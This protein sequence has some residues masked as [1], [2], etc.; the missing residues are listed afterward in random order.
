MSST[1][2]HDRLAGLRLGRLATPWLVYALFFV[3]GV[4][5]AAVV[6]LL[7]RLSARYG[8][9]GAETALLLA[10]PGLATLAVSVPSGLAADRFGARRVTLAAGVLLCLAC[11]SE[12]APSLIALLLGRVAFGIA[13]GVVWTTGMAWLADVDEM[14]A[15]RLGPSVTW[16]S[17]G[18]MVGPAVGGVL[19]QDAGLAAPFMAI[20]LTTAVVIVPLAFA[21]GHARRHRPAAGGER[22]RAGSPR[23]LLSLVR[24]PRVRAAAG[25][26]VVSGAVSSASQLLISGDLHRLDMSTGRIGLLFSAA[27]VCYLVV[28]AAIV[29][30]GDR[31]RTLRFN[32]AATAVLALGLLP[33]LAGAGVLALVAALLLTAAPRAAISTIAYSLAADR[34]SE[35]TD[36]DGFVFGI[37]NGAWAAATVL[38]PLVAGAVLQSSG[39]RAAY[40]A[41]IG[42][43]CGI[44]LWLLVRSRPGRTKVAQAV[45]GRP[46]RRLSR[47][48]SRRRRPAGA[49]ARP[50][51]YGSECRGRPPLHAAPARWFRRSP[52]SCVG[53]GSETGSP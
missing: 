27:A 37:L 25:A 15:G 46:P 53:S 6:P 9:S 22:E 31:A 5:Q 10:L 24:R 30:L 34:S 39:S 52:R 14:G 40:L 51:G 20:A 49:A 4:A 38:M 19:A 47:A 33:A 43:S 26:L 21:S 41:V 18:I 16:S 28:S 11:L 8:L 2:I 1:A 13:F 3:A 32:A 48:P 17:V 35:R 44:A 23:G 7:P 12:A 36:A 29:A 45:T 42:P 50:A